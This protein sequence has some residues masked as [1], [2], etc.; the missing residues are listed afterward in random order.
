MNINVRTINLELWNIHILIGGLLNVVNWH[1]E[2]I[3]FLANLI[4]FKNMYRTYQAVYNINRLWSEKVNTI[5]S[6]TEIYSS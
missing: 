3:T 2:Q 6:Y 5:G 4:N 1:M